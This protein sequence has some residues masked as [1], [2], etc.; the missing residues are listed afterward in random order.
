MSLNSKDNPFKGLPYIALVRASDD[1]EGK[2]STKAQLEWMHEDGRR[3]EMQHVDDEVL[4]GVT[5]SLPGRRED[6]ERLL[7]RRAKQRDFK[8]LLVQRCD[9]LSRGGGAHTLWFVHEANKVGLIVHFAGDDIPPPG[10]TFRNS[11]LAMK[12]DAAQ[13]HAKS[14]S[15][16]SVQGSMYSIEQGFNCVISRTPFGCDRL[17]LTSDGRPEF[18]IRN[19]GDGRQQ[20][21][22]HETGD[23]VDTYGRI[24]GGNKGH[25]DNRRTSGYS[26]SPARRRPPTQPASFSTS[27]TTDAGAASASLI[28]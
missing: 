8:V 13:E 9:R 5:G 28:T 4:S 12:A 6:L 23:V 27:V 3:L 18:I 21:L 15:Q 25:Y 24:G 7:R 14:I 22:H 26:L 20:K 10:S 11:F 19:L 1:T 16:R 17:Y 2:N